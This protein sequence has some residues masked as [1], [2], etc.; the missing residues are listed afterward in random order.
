[1]RFSL[2][3]LALL[4]AS[5]RPVC[6]AEKPP[7][8]PTTDTLIPNAQRQLAEEHAQINDNFV[9]IGQR[10]APLKE[11]SVIL[12]DGEPTLPAA[13]ILPVKIVRREGHKKSPAQP[14]VQAAPALLEP[15]PSPV[16]KSPDALG[17]APSEF[18]P[19]PKFAADEDNATFVRDEKSGNIVRQPV[20]TK[21][22]PL[23]TSY[24]TTS[25]RDTAPRS[26][27]MHS[28]SSATTTISDSAG[29]AD[30]PDLDC[31]ER[32]GCGHRQH[33]CC[34][35]CVPVWAHYTGGMGGYLFLRARNTS[36][37]YAVP[38]NV[39]QASSGPY[40]VPTGSI[41]TIDANYDSGFRA[42]FN[43]ALDLYSSIRFIYSY[44][45]NGEN[46]R[47]AGSAGGLL[48]SPISIGPSGPWLAAAATSSINM[49][50]ADLDFRKLWLYGPN[51]AVNAVIGA[52]YAHLNQGFGAN[53][54]GFI[55]DDGFVQEQVGSQVNFDGG[56]IRLG[57]EGDHFATNT[58]FLI[59]TRG[60]ASFVGGQFR[61]NYTQ[62]ADITPNTA[63]A[64]WRSGRLVS[65]LDAEIGVGWTS[66]N[67]RIRFRAGYLVSGWFN[68]VT[69]AHYIDAVRQNNYTGLSNAF[70]FDGLTSSVELRF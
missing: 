17:I 68:T 35:D 27:T 61:A 40:V 13:E 2:V 23:V 22:A 47:T 30:C 37:T 25:P 19:D 43:K 52:R 15:S 50:L 10:T 48:Y 44:F 32:N 16:S 21:P 69:T 24:R 4:L 31:A 49:Q 54:I 1:M 8:M 5:V 55:G 53:Y 63:V 9:E 46:D 51:H 12:R 70:S 67:Q 60:F 18:N 34:K 6:G 64:Y 58:G 59:Y 38:A 45:Q 66:P 3:L 62:T 26:A 7:T 36:T 42:G 41:G 11:Q 14:S 39:G 29:G 28:I 65:I 56:G 57:L 33:C 20:E